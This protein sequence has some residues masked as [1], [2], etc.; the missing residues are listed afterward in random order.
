MFMLGGLI[1]AVFYI[2]TDGMMVLNM[3]TNDVICV[4]LYFR[5]SGVT[6]L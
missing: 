4:D 2:K 3:S 5:L 6:G 1:T